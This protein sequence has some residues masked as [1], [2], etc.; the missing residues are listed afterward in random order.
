MLKRSLT[1]KS[2]AVA[3]VCALIGSAA[4]AAVTA[5]EAKALGTTLT[6]FG[7]EKS[8]NADGSIPAYTGGIKPPAGYGKDSEQYID[9]FK[10]E[11]PLYTVDAKNESTYA[12]MLTEGTKAML[13]KYPSYRL[14][15]YPTHRSVWYPDWVQENSVKNATGAKLS[16]EV[17]GDSVKG[18]AADDLPFAGVPFPIPKNGYEVMWNHKMSYGAPITHMKAS[19]W[20]V[21][22]SGGINGLPVTDEFFVRP[23]YDKT[24]YL[25]KETFNAINGFSTVLTDPPSS[26]GIRFLNYYLATA[27]DGGQKI[28]FYTPGQRRVRAAPEFAYDIPIAS[29]GGVLLW[30][31]VYGFV[32]RMDRFD[33][34]LVGKKEMLIPYNDFELTNQLPAKDTLDAKHLKPEAVRWEKH[35]VWVVTA[36]RKE[37]ARHVYSK[38]TFYVDEDCWC[39]VANESYD[40]A[41]NLWRVGYTYTYPTYDVGGVD[42]TAW[43][44]ND[45][46]KGNYFVVNIGHKDPGFFMRSYTSAEGLPVKLTPQAVAGGSIQ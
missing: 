29:Y 11:K 45:L 14:N 16:G 38:R 21:G 20:L 3:S 12:S 2:C 17:E 37:G 27:N 26:A 46:I 7:A 8:A 24:G 39:V 25:R 1:L 30:D 36:T 35:R 9:P 13:Q 31:E 44:Y 23:W 10:D 32:G 34:K 41:G 33:F 43:S 4:S 6:Q 42:N 5:D 22:P 18:G 19:A 40:N 15:V 28:W